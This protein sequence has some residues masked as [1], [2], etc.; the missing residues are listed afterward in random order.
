M[1][2]PDLKADLERRVRAEFGLEVQ[3][4]TR[5]SGGAQNRLFELQ[6]HQGMKLLAKQYAVDRWPRL[7]TEFATLRA[8][9]THGLERV[10]R[11]LLRD[12]EKSYAVYS[13]EPGTPRPA[14][15]LSPSD[16][17]QVAAFCAD[18]HRLGP[19]ELGGELAP[20]PDASFSPAGQRA[21]I[22]GRLG[23]FEAFATTPAA[24]DDLRKAHQSLDLPTRVNRLL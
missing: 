20:A 21:V 6:T 1:T 17:D 9:N 7:A 23:A 11:A 5:L 3:S 8:L 19:R 14:A 22:L 2:L 15:D 4:W 16:V 24:P 18:L 10:P 13:F 12:D